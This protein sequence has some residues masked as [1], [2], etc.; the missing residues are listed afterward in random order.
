MPPVLSPDE[1][2]ALKR[3]LKREAA[4]AVEGAHLYAMVDATREPFLVRPMLEAM[5][6]DVACL[7]KGLATEAFGD[8]TAWVAKIN[9]GE[10]ILDW[11]IEDGWGVRLASYIASPLPLEPLMTHLR[12]FTKVEGPD[13]RQ[14][15]FRFYDP[16]VMRQYL[17]VFDDRQHARWFAGIAACLIEDDRDPRRLLR[18]TSEGGRC[19]TA[20]VAWHLALAPL[21][22]V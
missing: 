8:R 21:E 10:W 17:P 19:V 3:A 5:S 4:A 20:R 13:G 18:L 22:T 16:R 12:R 9:E 14:H 7:F 2:D 1:Q 6:K 15:F 11:L